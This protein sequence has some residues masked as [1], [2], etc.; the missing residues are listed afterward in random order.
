MTLMDDAVMLLSIKKKKR[1][2]NKL[3]KRMEICYALI[4]GKIATKF[5][6]YLV[7]EWRRK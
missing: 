2:L 5:S 1:D 3:F 7:G 6:R 4:H